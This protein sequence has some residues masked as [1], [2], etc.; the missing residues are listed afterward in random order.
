[1]PVKNQFTTYMVV[2]LLIFPFTAAR[3][4]NGGNSKPKIVTTATF[5]TFLESAMSNACE[6]PGSPFSCY[7]KDLNSCKAALEKTK[8]ECI[9]QLRT[10]LPQEIDLNNADHI[11]E[12]FGRCTVDNFISGLGPEN[13]QMGKCKK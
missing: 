1:M 12:Q 7:S 3:S 10:T 9:S 11:K 5:L 13:L 6:D 4:D 2:L 8:S